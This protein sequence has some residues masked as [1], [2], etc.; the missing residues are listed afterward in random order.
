MKVAQLIWTS[1]A[2]S[3]LEIF[4]D[5]LADKSPLAAERISKRILERTR[6]LEEFPESGANFQLPTSNF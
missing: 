2:I 5:F 6:Q 1:E 4:Y 3:D